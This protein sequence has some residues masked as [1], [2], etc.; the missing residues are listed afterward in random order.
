MSSELDEANFTTYEELA[1]IE[2]EFE[3]VDTETS[4]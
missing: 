2:R 1:L 3:V 4:D